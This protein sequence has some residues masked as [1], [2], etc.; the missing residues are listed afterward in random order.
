MG[1]ASGIGAQL[2][3]G[4]GS[5]SGTCT[6]TGAA[7]F[8]ASAVG[9]S[10]VS[11]TGAA[12]ATSTASGT[13]TGSVSKAGTYGTLT[14]NETSGTYSFAPNASAISALT[15]DTSE[16]FPKLRAAGW[17]GYWIDA[18]STF[19][20]QY[21][22]WALVAAFLAAIIEAVAILGTVIPG[23]FILMG[24]AGAAAIVS[25]ITPAFA[26]E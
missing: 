16:I 2:S 20:A 4:V 3:A 12:T 8:T 19:I 21:P 23:T 9:T 26:A 15:S 22:M 17:K 24:I 25:E 7:G 14:V 10:T 5:S 11:A 18:A 6:A 1:T 13:G